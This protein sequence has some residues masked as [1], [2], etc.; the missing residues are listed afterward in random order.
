MKTPPII[1]IVFCGA[2]RLAFAQDA[3]AGAP[4]AAP[5]DAT[6]KAAAAHDIAV[7]TG[8]PTRNPGAD[9]ASPPRRR[10][11]QPDFRSPHGDIEGFTLGRQYNLEYLSLADVG[12]PFHSGTAGRAS[13]LVGPN[14]L[15]ANDNV[16]YYSNRS[17]HLSSGASW[18]VDTLGGD[19]LADRAWGMTVGVDMGMFSLRA[20]HQNR[21]VAQVHLYD[22][23]GAN[24]DAKNSLIAANL[25]MRWGT[26][27]A[28]YAANRGWG[29]SPLY[30][31]DNPYGAGVASTSS[32][33]SRD[34]LVGVAVPMTNS[35]TFLASFIHKNDRDLA[36]RDANQFAV[37]A[38]YV[39]SRKTDFYTAV[40]R[41]ITT[42]GNGLLVGGAAHP[43]GSLAVN[44]GMRHAF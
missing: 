30:N 2:A 8:V 28:A 10:Y 20:A 5:A 7:F 21:H 22:L 11:G 44:I 32:T 17:E 15:R 19:P 40:S 38:S 6:A 4:P 25:R 37:G 35:T 13:N 41:T 43:S 34:T 23:A 31:P 26:A 24:M 36:N 3:A 33:D 18:T 27:Y 29:S 42:N 14:G 1:A 9:W 39:V 16:R 12:D